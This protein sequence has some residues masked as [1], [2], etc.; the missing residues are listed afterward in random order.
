M[1]EAN[2]FVQMVAVIA[3]CN[4]G[5]LIA[6]AL[7]FVPLLVSYSHGVNL[8]LPQLEQGLLENRLWA[9]DLVS[10]THYLLIV[11]ATGAWFIHLLSGDA[12]LLPWKRAQTAQNKG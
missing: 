10:D 1:S 11:W 5:L 8:T 2:K 9:I 12:R 3:W 7:K 6:G 4:F